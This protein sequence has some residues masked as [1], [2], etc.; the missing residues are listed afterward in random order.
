[1]IRVMEG[2]DYGSSRDQTFET[3]RLFISSHVFQKSILKFKSS[4]L[5]LLSLYSSTVTVLLLKER[6]GVNSG[7]YLQKEEERT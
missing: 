3:Q 7:R 1:M 5:T 2:L 4:V 6:E